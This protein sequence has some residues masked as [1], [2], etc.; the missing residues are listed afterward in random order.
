VNGKFDR[1]KLIAKL[2]PA[3]LREDCESEIADASAA[4]ALAFTSR[5]LTQVT[6]PHKK[7]EGSIYKRK[8]GKLSLSV[9]AM[10]GSKGL[11][12]GTYPRLLIAWMT[13]EAV[14][15]KSQTLE[16]GDS[17]SDF[18]QKL[19]LVP[20]G[21]RWGSVTRLRDHCDR[22]FNA[23]IGWRYEG[24]KELAFGGVKP[25]V[26]A[27]LWWDHRAPGQ[28]STFASVVKLSAEFYAE[29]VSRP[30]PVDMRV[31]KALAKLRSPFALDLYTWLTYRVSYLERPT[32]IGWE[33][34]AF[35]FGSDFKCLRD[36]RKSVTRWLRIVKQVA[37][38]PDLSA[39]P[40]KE[41]LILGPSLPHVLPKHLN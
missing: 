24:S 40:T 38:W 33:W 21:G 32:T 41:G 5:L 7:T 26:G 27:Y 8:N 37:D 1:A 15:S 3:H 6:L 36:F 18:M 29:L 10:P 16:L 4:G 31:L 9:V 2:T 39:Q 22:L 30:V 34:L 20:T 25:V 14:R 23:T 17:L 12:Y 28:L 19:A 13:T 11:P 35:Q